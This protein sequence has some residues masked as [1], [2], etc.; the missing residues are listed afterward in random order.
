M[1]FG[2]CLYLFFTLGQFA[3]P[4]QGLSVD[5]VTN[6]SY[7]LSVDGVTWLTSGA[8]FF[9][10]A[11]RRYSTSDRS[12]ALVS[13]TATS[14]QDAFGQWQ[15]TSFNYQA[16]PLPVTASIKTYNE[17]NLPL[18]IFSQTYTGSATRA[19]DSDSDHVISSFPCFKTFPGS[20]V[21]LGFLSYGGFHSGYS[22]LTTGRQVM[23]VVTG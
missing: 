7:S 2:F 15:S 20:S 14:G 8:T 3:S 18:V 13:T 5:I 17:P 4:Q 23:S 6:G 10:N 22:A 9:N 16:G 1:L 12:L 21:D 11:W 19:A